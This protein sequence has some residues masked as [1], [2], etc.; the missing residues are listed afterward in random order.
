MVSVVAVE[1]ERVAAVSVAL[2]VA[3]T[4]NNN[5]NDHH[6]RAMIWFNTHSYGR[7]RPRSW[8]R[9]RR[10]SWGFWLAIAH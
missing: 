2:D 7:S 1:L 6:Q 3:E 5:N 10:R 8:R 9:G 4:H